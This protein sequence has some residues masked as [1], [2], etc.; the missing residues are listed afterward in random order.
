M[1]HLK[2]AA[3]QRRRRSA[4]RGVTLFEVLIVVAILALVASGV[5]IAAFGEFGNA[6]D[7]LAATNARSLRSVVK[8]WW[9]SH[10]SATCPRIEDLRADGALDKDSPARD[11]WGGPWQIECANEDVT[12]ISNGKDRK[13]DT[14]DDIRIPPT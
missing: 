3:P 14:E 4:V 1:R 5:G 6:R 7:K 9:V 10:D 2:P 13:H 8:T 12:I 11:P